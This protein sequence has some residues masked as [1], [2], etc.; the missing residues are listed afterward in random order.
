MLAAL[1][2]K[3]DGLV[4]DLCLLVVK[5]MAPIECFLRPDDDVFRH[6]LASSWYLFTS[7]CTG[8]GSL[9]KG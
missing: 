1:V 2:G 8:H 9:D 7:N 5:G 4:M 3:I 6:F